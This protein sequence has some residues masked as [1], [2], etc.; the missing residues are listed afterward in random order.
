[1][2]QIGDMKFVDFE[3]IPSNSIAVGNPCKVIKNL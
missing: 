2:E 3:D 1:M